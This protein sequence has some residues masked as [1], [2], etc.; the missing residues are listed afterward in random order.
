VMAAMNEF[1]RRLD[2][3]EIGALYRDL[4][5]I[6]DRRATA[7]NERL[8]DSGLPVRLA[9]L[10]SIWIIYYTR[11]SAYNWMFQYYLR[12][13]GLALSWVGTGRLIFSL[14]YTEADYQAVADRFVASAEAMERGGW[15]WEDP[16][17]NNRKIKRRI[18]RE[19]VAHR[20]SL[21]RT[22]RARG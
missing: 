22:E 7:L 3:P 16:V 1:L 8:R 13:E 17:A 11:P 15:W 10:S 20:L 2:E 6:W 9:N 21:Q 19:I 18:L 4:D 12:A 14:N 5:E